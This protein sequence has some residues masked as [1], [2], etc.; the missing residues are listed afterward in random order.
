MGEE[1]FLGAHLAAQKRGYYR[2][3]LACGDYFQDS[4]C[5]GGDEGS[6]LRGNACEGG[7]WA[8]V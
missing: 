4:S 2:L 8:G 1:F 7:G 5:L 6:S 3:A